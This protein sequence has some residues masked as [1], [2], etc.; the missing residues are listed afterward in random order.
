MVGLNL[1]G[2]FAVT[3]APP[4]GPFL[5]EFTILRAAVAQD[6]IGVAGAFLA[7]LLLVFIG[8]GA[9]VLAV[10]Q[11]EPAP[12]RAPAR[13]R[14]AQIAPIAALLGLVLLLGIWIPEPLAAALWSA[15]HYIEGV[16]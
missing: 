7:L 5:S 3:G 4:F 9:T 13:E 12:E 1:V 6:R 16:R 14:F 15:A 2:F 10:V 11:G 8:M